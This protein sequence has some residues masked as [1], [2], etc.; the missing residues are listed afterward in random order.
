M[1]VCYQCGNEVDLGTI[2]RRYKV[3]DRYCLRCDPDPLVW[4]DRFR[5]EDVDRASLENVR[6]AIGMSHSEFASVLAEMTAAGEEALFEELLGDRYREL[7]AA[8]AELN[9][10]IG[11]DH[12]EKVTHRAIAGVAWRAIKQT[13]A[14]DTLVFNWERNG[15][16]AWVDPKGTRALPLS[17]GEQRAMRRYAELGGNP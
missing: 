10:R 13:H 16:Y 7:N 3:D 9:Q 11:N 5:G 8:I 15:E 17:P 14:P 6:N 1:S 2:E 12:D 4:V